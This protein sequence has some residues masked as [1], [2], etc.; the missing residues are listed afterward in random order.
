MNFYG[1]ARVSSKGQ[2]LDRQLIDL[3]NFG[4][5][6]IYSD[7][8]SGANFSRKEYQK[9]RRKLKTDDVLVIKS[10]DRLGRN[11]SDVIDEWKYLTTIKKVDI[12]VLDMPLLDTRQNKDLLGTFIADLVLGLLSYISQTEREMIR[13]RQLDGIK[14]AK[15]NGVKFG[16]PFV[17]YPENF[18]KIYIAYKSK[19]ISRE[20]ALIHLNISSKEFIALCRRYKRRPPI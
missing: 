16:R 20:D 2:K 11:Y 19:V 7:K 14:I 15:K 5:R 9:M 18:L 8:V 3:E 17:D 6:Y 10:L 4:V 12:V 13:S 1:Y